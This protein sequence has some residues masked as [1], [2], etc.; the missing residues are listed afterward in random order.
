MP[1]LMVFAMA[2]PVVVCD[3]LVGVFVLMT[4]GEVQPNADSHQ[5]SDQRD[6]DR[7]TEQYRE[8]CAEEWGDRE[9][10][11][12]TGGADMTHCD[13]EEHEADTVGEEP[14]EHRASNIHDRGQLCPE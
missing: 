11:S 14:H 10:G 12:G 4:L 8:Q 2:M 1:V 9:V 7:P 5:G 3:R 13:E 6:G